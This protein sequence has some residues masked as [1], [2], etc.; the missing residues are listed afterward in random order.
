MS[1]AI[2]DKPTALPGKQTQQARVWRCQFCANGHHGSCPG[3]VRQIRRIGKT[4]RTENY[5]W[6][7]ECKESG[8]PGLHCLECKND[9]PDE[10]D[11]KTWECLDRYV[12]AGL[13]Q[14]RRENSQLWQMI[15][16]AKSHSAIKR[17]A[18]RLGVE[19]TLSALDTDFDVTVERMHEMMDSLEQARGTG[20][21]K[22][23]GTP[24]PKTGQCECC[25]ESTRGGRFLP[26]HDAKLASSLRLR[27]KNGDQAAYDEMKRRGWLSK[28]P[29]E[30]QGGVRK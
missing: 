8:H 28:L 15:Q 2:L 22:K 23:K 18:K 1:V 13:L 19:I 7:C 14:K 5:L 30:L 10:V 12:C 26:G 16:H 27:V 17:R 29:T 4:E 11:S 20:Q 25:G 21:T 6:L 9:N 3:A 24:K